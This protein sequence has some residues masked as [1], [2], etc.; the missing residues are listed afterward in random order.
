MLY[1]ENA[2]INT[3]VYNVF[4]IKEKN[5]NLSVSLQSNIKYNVPHATGS[6]AFDLSVGAT[7]VAWVDECSMQKITICARYKMAD[8]ESNMALLEIGMISGYVPD[9]LHSLLED[10]ATSEYTSPPRRQS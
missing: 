4:H 7:S 1:C 8:G 2:V 10:P 3:T 6:E 9:R 5:T